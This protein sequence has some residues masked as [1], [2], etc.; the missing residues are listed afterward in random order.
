MPKFTVIGIH[1]HSGQI[2]AEHVEA[3]NR[4]HAFFVCASYEN[5]SDADFV[6]AI[7]GHNLEG[8]LINFA[9]DSLVDADTILEQPEVFC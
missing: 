2:F 8:A 1:S 7:D 5:Y 6:C 9:G 3:N 4:T